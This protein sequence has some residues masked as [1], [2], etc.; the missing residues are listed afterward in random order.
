MTHLTALSDDAP[1]LCSS[2]VPILVVIHWIGIDYGL[3]LPLDLAAV[4]GAAPGEEAEVGVQSHHVIPA[5]WT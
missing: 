5:R 1:S 2:Y 4:R 3:E